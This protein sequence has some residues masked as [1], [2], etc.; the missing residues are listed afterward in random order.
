MKHARWQILLGVFLVVLSAALY[1]LHFFIFH[2]AHH[3][4]VYLL[5]D[6]AF[7]PIEV[8]LVTLIIHRLLMGREKRLMFEK[9]NMV[10][11]TFFSQVGTELLARFSAH[12][13]GVAKIR[14]SLA[15]D[16]QWKKDDFK[17]VKKLLEQYPYEVQ[18]KNIDLPGLSSFL[19]A[20]RDFMVRLL[21]NPV[22]LE[23]GPFT[24]L[25][26]ATFHLTEELTK[27]E[28]F[29]RSPDTD[30]AHLGGDIKRVYRLLAARWLSYMEYLKTSYP[31]L[32]SLAMRTNPFDTERSVVVRS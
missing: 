12:D 20:Q 2:D 15:V 24:D 29:S 10:I 14:D 1:T 23:H 6:I 31:Y 32:F 27:R 7:V 21:E 25:L 26:R 18:V 16:G 3:I 19:R 5:G 9:L 30:I 13:P 28:D 11:G 17:R 8:L 22:L 4:F